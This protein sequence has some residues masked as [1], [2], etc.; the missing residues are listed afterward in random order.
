MTGMTAVAEWF[1]RNC[2]GDWEH[3]HGVR[4]HSLDNPGW[5]LEIDIGDTNLVGVPFERVAIEATDDDWMVCVVEAGVFKGHCS[6]SHLE[7]MLAV[8][9]EWAAANR[10]RQ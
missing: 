3:Q 6:V 8:F 2:D 9:L 5:A 10:S 7:R 1:R 4:I